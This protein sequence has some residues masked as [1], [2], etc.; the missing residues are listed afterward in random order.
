[1]RVLVTGGTGKVGRTAVAR[2]VR[3]GHVVRVIGRRPDVTIEQA[4][5]RS[6]DINDY[7]A[8]RDQVRGVEAI[9]HLAAIRHPSLGPGQEIFRVN[10]SGT[11]NIYHAAAAEGV[12]RVV[13]ASSINALGYNFGTKEFALQY[14][15]IDEEHPSFTTDPYSFSKQIVE[16]IAAYFW[17]REGISGIC[18]RLPA[19]YENTDRDRGVTSFLMLAQDAY[20]AFFALSPAERQRRAAQIIARFEAMRSE[21]AWERPTYRFGMDQPD[22]GLMFGRSNF[23]TSINA[24][25]SAQA[26]E[27]GLLAHYD[28]SHPLYINDSHN[29]VGVDTEVL[30]R[31]FFP[32]VTTWK[33]AV[34]GTESLVSIDRARA[35]IGFEPQHSIQQRPQD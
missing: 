8:I 31:T 18:L 32:G 25:D 24:E 23:W 35:L 20:T 22:A 21:R 33:R 16:E 2:L 19:V 9:V 5:Y 1:V 30:A 13:T 10:C 15:P 26:I 4:E 28:G 12:S 29:F 34:H 6:C 3:Q 11:F 27:K 17:R 14:F 7:E